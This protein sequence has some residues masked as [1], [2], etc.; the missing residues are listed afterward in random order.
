MAESQRTERSG[1]MAGTWGTKPQAQVRGMTQTGVTGKEG[2]PGRMGGGKL[3]K[4]AWDSYHCGGPVPETG[5]WEQQKRG[6]LVMWAKAQEQG[7]IH[8]FIPSSS[9]STSIW[10]PVLGHQGIQSKPRSL[11]IPSGN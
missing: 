9:H 7:S 1:W 8:P 10:V 6:C 3:R 4:R 5:I 11:R 2:A